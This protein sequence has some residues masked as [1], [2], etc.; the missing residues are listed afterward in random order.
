[1]S[2]KYAVSILTPLCGTSWRSSLP[3]I[4][5]CRKHGVS[6]S[7][8]QP[9]D[10]NVSLKVFQVVLLVKERMYFKLVGGKVKSI[11]P[12]MTELNQL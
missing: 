12:F 9:F 3:S 2:L 10:P 6:H 7:F 5:I 11:H 1:M 4:E 8:H